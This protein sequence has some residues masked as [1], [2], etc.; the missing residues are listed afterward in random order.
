MFVYKFDK[1]IP[2]GIF[3]ALIAA[4]SV[5]EARA[6]MLSKHKEL[7]DDHNAGDLETMELEMQDYTVNLEFAKILMIAYFE[8]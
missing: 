6:L 3:R 5:L 7:C 8:D 1:R 4:H 2:M